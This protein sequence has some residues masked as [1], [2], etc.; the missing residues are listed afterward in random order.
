MYK[1]FLLPLLL[2]FSL[3]GLTLSTVPALAQQNSVL[4]SL[5]QSDD[6]FLPVDQAFV[7][8]FRQQDDE[9]I[10][11]WTIA[12]GYYMYRDKFKYG[13]VAVSFSHPTYPASMQIEDEFFGVTEV[14]FHQLT[15]KIPL[16]D[17]SEDAFLRIQYMGCAEAGLCYPPVN[18]E[19]PIS[20]PG[21]AAASDDSATPQGG[22]PTSSQY[23]LAERLSSGSV[24]LNMGVFFLLGL[25][26]AF[27]PCVFPMYPIL[28]SIIV[29]QGKQL[30]TRRAFSL[31]FSYVQG[32]AIM[33]SAL[34]LVVA[35]LGVK[36]QAWMQHPAVLISA[37]VIFVLL[38]LAMFGG[39]NF[40]LPAS[41]QAKVSSVSN[42]QQGGSIKGAFVM[43]AL[44]GLIASPCTT[45]PLSAAL[46]YVAQ[47]GDL[48]LG[49]LTLYVLSLGMGIPLILLGTSGGKLLPKA[50]AWMNIV[51][52]AFGFVLLL[53]PIILLERILPFWQVVILA[54]L[55][56]LL[57]C[58]YLFKLLFELKSSTAKAGM[59][60]TG[61]LLL[62]VTVLFN[63]QYFG[64]GQATA[65]TASVASNKGQFI[66][67]D[68]LAGLEQQLAEAKAANEYTLV[69]LY[70]EWC[71]ACK[72]FEQ[73]TFPAAQVQAHTSKMRLIKI[74]VTKMT[75]SDEKLLNHYQ[76][77]GLPTLLFFNPA[78]EELTNARVTGFMA[79]S[80]FAEHLAAL[81]TE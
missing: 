42:K 23:G 56:S 5:L 76:V 15:L 60:L 11:N 62:L 18:K 46:L 1:V 20:M 27:T 55:L 2:W 50:G 12:D 59:L 68:D 28:S 74:D 52:T 25:G 21:N 9:L 37:A 7:M 3:L 32:M 29:G 73:F 39:F 16:S 72:E 53:V 30:S 71:V 24:W 64:P 40:Q 61:L 48:M 70:A 57:I 36:F 26:L 14:Y 78:G 67:V 81:T 13:G 65:A 51:K 33:Y 69:D 35:S 80:P 38:A 75:R 66:N 6:D 58:G 43:G 63:W 47:S 45:A 79:A 34:G 8:D 17:I 77:L 31:S 19:I 4:G 41:W 22:T 44:S 54:S 10:V 49:A